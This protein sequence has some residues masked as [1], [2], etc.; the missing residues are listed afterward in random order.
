VKKYKLMIV[1]DHDVV[2]MGIITLLEDSEFEV[3]N[4]ASSVAETLEKVAKEKPDVILMDVRLSD[5]SGID[6]CRQIVENYPEVRVLIVTSYADD[7]AVLS[8]ILAG[9]SG[10][11][12]KQIDRQALRDAI[13][14]VVSGEAMLDPSIT[15]SLFTYLRH[16]TLQPKYEDKFQGLTGKEREIL[17]QV[18]MGKSNRQIAQELFLSEYTVRNYVSSILS[19]LN[20][21]NRIQIANYVHERGIDFSDG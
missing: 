2:R 9:A 6:A 19:K 4:E 3:I 8:S 16:N 18:S 21:T 5:G 13:R 7:D 12:L 10:Y 15:M 1:D 14:K 20:L 17:I 11:V